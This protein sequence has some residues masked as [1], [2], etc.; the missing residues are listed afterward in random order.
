MFIISFRE[1]R[2]FNRKLLDSCV[3]FTEG[4]SVNMIFPVTNLQEIVLEATLILKW[5][6]N[7][8]RMFLLN[9]YLFV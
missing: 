4:N 5:R 9:T 1:D 2:H 3:E 8:C 7:N 6:R